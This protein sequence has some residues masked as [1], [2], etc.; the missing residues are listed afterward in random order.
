MAI[1]IG[2]KNF[3][4]GLTLVFY[5]VGQ[6]LGAFF[7]VALGSFT[8]GKFNLLN[9]ALIPKQ[10]TYLPADRECKNFNGNKCID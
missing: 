9:I 3:N 5:I 8:W 4:R 2:R 6:I 10:S 1:F 7:A